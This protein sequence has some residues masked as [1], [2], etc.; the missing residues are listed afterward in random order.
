MNK[1]V[2]LIFSEWFYPGYKAGVPV[3]SLLNMISNL[4]DDF[5]FRV[6]TTNCDYTE[7]EPYPDLIPGSWQK[8]PFDIPVYYFDY[9]KVNGSEIGELITEVNPD[10]IHING[11]YSKFFCRVPLKFVSG[12]KKILK[13]VSV[14]GMLAPSALA[15]KSLKKK[16]YLNLARWNAW[17]SD[18]VFHA[19][20]EMEREQVL[21]HFPGAKVKVAPNVPAKCP[22][23]F[24]PA[25]FT[26][27][28]LDLVSVSRIAPEKNILG[29]IEALAVISQLPEFS[30]LQISWRIF[31]PV[32]D[33][34][35]YSRCLAL[36]DKHKTRFSVKFEGPLNPLSIN[37]EV[38]KAH[39]FFHPSFAENFGHSV[40]QGF[41]AARPVIC[42][43]KTP[44]TDIET[45][46]AGFLFNPDDSSSLSGALA[47]LLKLNP[48]DFRSACKNAFEYGKRISN[49]EKV[50]VLNK[51]LFNKD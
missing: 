27:E 3:E 7:R 16:I 50:L 2:V 18:V 29:G 19:T 8:G 10:V 24:S 40:V 6:I 34:Q 12:N 44:W 30:H 41:Y 20:N 37:M 47:R 13:I 28:K 45:Q 35:Y 43:R 36:S 17:F 1:P 49:N 23:S 26:G 42:S 5:D 9:G 21:T 39:A 51:S 22:D 32:Y 4:K 48:D 46:N 11:I 14:R 15:I 38:S 25:E 33:P 31:G